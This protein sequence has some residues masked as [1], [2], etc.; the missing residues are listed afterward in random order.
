M[1][2]GSQRGFSGAKI[3]D[4]FSYPSIPDNLFLISLSEGMS[5]HLAVEWGP[6]GVRVNCVAPGAV[7]DTEGFRRLG[8]KLQRIT[9][10]NRICIFYLH[11][12]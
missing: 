2:S 6:D 1:R 5:R 3:S 7:K 8:N 4:V 9:V 11:L 10:G 12:I